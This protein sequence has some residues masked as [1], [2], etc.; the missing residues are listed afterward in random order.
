MK[1][2]TVLLKDAEIDAF[3]DM[4]FLLSWFWQA[5]IDKLIAATMEVRCGHDQ[6]LSELVANEDPICGSRR[7]IYCLELSKPELG[8]HKRSR[9]ALHVVEAIIIIITDILQASRSLLSS[10]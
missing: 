9:C 3:A 1:N 2:V 8:F 4:L 7:V 6:S 5:T 10:S